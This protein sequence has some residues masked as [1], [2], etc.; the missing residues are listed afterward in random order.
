MKS[1]T[2]GRS[3]VLYARVSTILQQNAKA[4]LAELRTVGRARGWKIV[5]E[6]TEQ[7]SGADDARPRFAEAMAVLASGRGQILATVSLDR[8]TRSLA[9]LLQVVD[10]IRTYGADLVCVRDGDL[11]TTTASGR[12]FLQVR[13][14]FAELERAL[15]SERAREFAAVR[16]AQGLPNGRPSTMSL[17]AVV[18]A[19]ALRRQVVVGDGDQRP[20]TWSE[21]AGQ[22]RAEGF[23]EIT[24]AT[25]CRRVG[26]AVR[27]PPRKSAA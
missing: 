22:L 12:A 25:I 14:V 27:N 1:I 2:S 7:A 3:V 24:P 4:Q 20:P 18:R 13:G 11:D 15:S 10:Q 17:G 6:F 26:E 8:V 9:H 21:I 19:I 23:G 16:K 5:A